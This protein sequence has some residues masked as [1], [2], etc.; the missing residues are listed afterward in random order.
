M[1]VAIGYLRCF[2]NVIDVKKI[3]ALLKNGALVNVM[4]AEVETPL[5]LG[6]ST[7]W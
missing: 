3:G 6:L 1:H 4:N 7:E 2:E 5:L